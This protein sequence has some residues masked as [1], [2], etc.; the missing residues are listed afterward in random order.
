[1]LKTCFKNWWNKLC[2]L[3]IQ[4]PK[5]SIC[6]KAIVVRNRQE[7]TLCFGMVKFCAFYVFDKVMSSENSKE[8][9]DLKYIAQF[10]KQLIGFGNTNLACGYPCLVCLTFQ[11]E[12]IVK[13]E[14]K[15]YI[16]LKKKQ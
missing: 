12:L 10:R 6:P 7:G 2:K 3:V 4:C 9:S 11:S 15:L 5:C 8:D 16:L 13:L 1:M 14:K